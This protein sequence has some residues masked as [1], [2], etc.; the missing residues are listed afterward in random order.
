M[1]PSIN[2]L[3]WVTVFAIA[4]AYLESAIVVYLRMLYYP[5]GF[6]FP[7]A[8]A[9]NSIIFIEIGREAA[10]M[11]MLVAIGFFCGRSPIERFAYLL[12]S[13]AV[14]DVGYY[15]WLK[16]FIGWP[17]SLL[18]WDVLFLI[19]LPWIGPVLA[20]LLVSFAM[21]WAGV[22]IIKRQD[23]GIT[24]RFSFRTW[25]AEIVCGLSIIF[26]FLWDIR[27][28]MQGVYPRPFRWEYFFPGLC[29]GS[30]IFYQQ[31]K[32]PNNQTLKS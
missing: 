26:S 15:V 24:P 11:I 7:L 13:F 4:M 32:S 28:V 31:M 25:C 9:P 23:Q 5:Q 14:W 29:A 18:T 17:P 1:R 30:V 8:A 19:P 22:W 2:K 21:M 10:T 6:D 27:N 3:I 16:I 20:P 12:Y